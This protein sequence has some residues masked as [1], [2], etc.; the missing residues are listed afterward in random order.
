MRARKHASKLATSSRFTPLQ[1]TTEERDGLWQKK[2]VAAF[3]RISERS[4]ETLVSQRQIPFLRLGHRTLRFRKADVLRALNRF[5]TT[6]I[7]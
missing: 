7:S 2:D 3:F 1:H 5:T 4:V 6:E